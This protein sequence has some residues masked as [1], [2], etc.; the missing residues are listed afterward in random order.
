MVSFG[1][2]KQVFGE[3]SILI[4]AKTQEV[5][6]F[7]AENFYLNYPKWA[8]EIIDLESLDDGKVFIGAKGR[9]VREDNEAK[10]ESFFEITEF[11]PN[12]QFV[13]QGIGRP[14][15]QT[16]QIEDEQEGVDTKLTFRFDL[17][18]IEL[19]MWPFEKLIRIAIEDGAENTVEHIRELMTAQHSQPN[20]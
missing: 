14:Y 15:K 10:I 7:V 8:P 18:E 5:F 9:Q 11:N 3:A 19:Y 20:Y 6:C 16:F 12:S 13:L 4:K 2:T 1:T 17:L